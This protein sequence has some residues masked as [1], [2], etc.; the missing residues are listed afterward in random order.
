MDV[1]FVTGA[2]GFV[3]ANLVRLLIE[4]G[5]Q[6][7]ALVRPSSD[8]GNLEKIDVEKVQGD[9][10]DKPSLRAACSGARFVFNVAADYRIFVPN[11]QEMYESNV[12]GSVNLV[13]AAHAQGAERI[14]HCSSVAAV[15]PPNL[16]EIADE[17]N[18]FADESEIVSVYKKSKWLSETAVLKKAREGVP[19]V[20]VNPAAP[21]GPYDLK[22]TP[23]GKIVTDFL[24]KKLPSYLDT[25]LNV[26]HVQDVAHGHYLAALKGK[27]GDRYILGGENMSFKAILDELADLTGLPSPRFQTPYPVAYAF[28]ALDTL[29]ARIFGGQ[30]IAPLDAVRMAKYKMYYDSQKAVRELGFAPKPAREALRDAVSWFCE[31]G[32]APVPPKL[33]GPNKRA[34]AF[35]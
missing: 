8:L 29:R 24:N 17:S 28:G 10:R 21:I 4:K 22:P 5:F 3:G 2:T 32:Y 7:R 18:E 26:V 15:K 34:C 20:V 30:P 13:E 19:V 1:A 6:V 9:L 35:P 33:S 12:T 11:P 31:N 16:G 25:G 23:T 27:V 14:V